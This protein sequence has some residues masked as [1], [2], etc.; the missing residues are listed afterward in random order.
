M[1]KT[2]NHRRYPMRGLT[3]VELLVTTAV[4]ASLLDLAVPAMGQLLAQWQ[5]NS[6]TKLFTAHFQLARSSA[7]KTS[8]RIVMCNSID[9]LLCANTNHKE[10]IGGWIVFPDSNAN[11]QRESAETIIVASGPTVGLKSFIASNKIR[12][13]VFK[14]NG[15]MSS[16]MS[17]LTVIPKNGSTM[18]IIISRTG[19]FRLSEASN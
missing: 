12:Q 6:A 14:P 4:L 13:F 9:G 19:R 5:R 7:I 16:G 15:L 17:T 10:W 11:S 3:L 1:H 8:R 18:K 2:L